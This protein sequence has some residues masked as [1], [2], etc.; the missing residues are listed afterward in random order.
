MKRAKA[1]LKVN[2]PAHMRGVKRAANELVETHTAMLEEEAKRRCPVDSGFLQSTIHRLRSIGKAKN[3]QEDGVI[4]GASY[5]LYVHNGTRN[6]RAQPF[7]LE[8]F[9]AVRAKFTVA[10]KALGLNYR[11]GKNNLG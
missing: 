5:A 9:E 7:L 6:Q 2:I 4:V 8:A 1:T 10:V 11:T 3:R